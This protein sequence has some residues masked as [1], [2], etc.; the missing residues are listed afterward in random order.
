MQGSPDATSKFSKSARFGFGSATREGIDKQKVPGPGAYSHRDYTGKEGAA[1]TCTPRRG[2]GL[3][4]LDKPGPG[5][6]NLPDLVGRMGPFHTLTP[7]RLDV[8]KSA[9]P[10]PGAYNQEDKDLIESQPRWGF[11][12]SQRPGLTSGQTTPGPGTYS[13]AHLLGKGTPTY[14]MQSRREGVKAQ[15]TPGPGTHGGIFTQF[16]Y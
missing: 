5:A 10:G 14:S 13:Q 7:R 3:N 16:G 15:I 2:A 12:T 8:K 11:G 6:H 4:G 1:V 9:I